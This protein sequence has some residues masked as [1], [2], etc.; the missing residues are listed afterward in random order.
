MLNILSLKEAT[1]RSGLLQW[2]SGKQTCPRGHVAIPICL[3]FDLPTRPPPPPLRLQADIKWVKRQTWGVTCWWTGMSAML[4]RV[5]GGARVCARCVTLTAFWH[6]GGKLGWAEKNGGGG[7]VRARKREGVERRAEQ[8]DEICRTQKKKKSPPPPPPTPHC[9]WWPKGSVSA[10]I[11]RHMPAPA[12]F[13]YS[14]LLFCRPR[15]S[16]KYTHDGTHTQNSICNFEVGTSSPTF[17]LAV[18]L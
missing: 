11:S 18:S 15:Q 8:K 14:Y 4:L 17:H 1:W 16:D 9:N 6:V 7:E 3:S 12:F 13:Y 2:I 10:L 5:C